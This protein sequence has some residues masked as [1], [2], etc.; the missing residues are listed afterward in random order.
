VRIGRASAE[1]A[2]ARI[3]RCNNADYQVPHD[4]CPLPKEILS[5]SAATCVEERAVHD[6]FDLQSRG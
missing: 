2:L 1:W 5:M 4:A 6:A 3:P